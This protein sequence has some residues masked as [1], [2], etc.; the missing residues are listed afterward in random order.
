MKLPRKSKYGS[1]HDE[2]RNGGEGEATPAKPAGL[3][4]LASATAAPVA[5]EHTATKDPNVLKSLQ[6]RMKVI[7]KE[8]SNKVCSE[9]RSKKPKWMSLLQAPIDQERK[10]LG[11]LCCE[12]CQAYHAA[13]GE[14]LCILKSLKYP[15]EC[16]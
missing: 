7:L 13:L 4:T 14:E 2:V 3:T 5:L 6:K 16:K 8:P 12:N 1:F 11:V 9:C 10:Q 15:E